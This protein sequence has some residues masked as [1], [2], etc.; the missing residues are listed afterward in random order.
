MCGVSLLVMLISAVITPESVGVKRTPIVQSALAPS[1]NA[2][3]P[4]GFAPA[5]KSSEKL[6]SVETMS[7][8][9]S[10]VVPQFLTV[11]TAVLVVATGVSPK[12]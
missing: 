7:W 9:S 12:P 10:A 5:P 11:R 3:L 4:H 2:P 6:P 8:I 1:E